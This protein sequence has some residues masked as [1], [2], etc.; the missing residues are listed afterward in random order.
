MPLLKCG[1][2]RMREVSGAVQL[3]QKL[4][5]KAGSPT[6][7]PSC[8]SDDGKHTCTCGGTC[9]AYKTSCRCFGAKPHNEGKKA[10]QK[11]KK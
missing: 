11:L 4:Q 6:G 5:Q 7:K 8:T 2:P 1:N 9:F 3:A 10:T